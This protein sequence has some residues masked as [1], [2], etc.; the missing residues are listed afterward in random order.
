MGH[1]SQGFQQPVTMKTFIVEENEVMET[2]SVK[3]KS[4]LSNK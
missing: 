1:H 4:S 2:E 3:H